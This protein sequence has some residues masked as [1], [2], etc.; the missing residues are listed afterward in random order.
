MAEGMKITLTA[1]G[2]GLTINE[3]GKRLL[4]DKHGLVFQCGPMESFELIRAFSSTNYDTITDGEY[5][6]KGARRL[7]TWTF[8]TIAMVLGE[9]TPQST[10]PSWVPFPTLDDA[11][12]PVPPEWYRDRIAEIHDS[13]SPFRF[14]A[15]M[16]GGPGAIKVNSTKASFGPIVAVPAIILGFT[17]SHVAGEGDAI[18]FKSMA[19]SEWRD[20]RVQERGLGKQGGEGRK[21]N[22]P[23]TVK[24]TKKGGIEGGPFFKGL[25]VKKVSAMD[26]AKFFYHD[27]SKWREIF[28]ANNIV[29]GSGSTPLIDLPKY[30]SLHAHNGVVATIQIPALDQSG[31]QMTNN[32]IPRGFGRGPG[33][34]QQG[35]F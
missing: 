8:D 32:P 29:G 21:T 15:T 22:L 3:K 10:T 4:P 19:F 23:T 9:T 28:L 27:P 13:G 26:L 14:T 2:G 6:R 7:K 25:S 20:P 35:T 18:Y 34:I 24:L 30:K 1:L 12:T 17:E 5:T 16:P 31:R 11:T 33:R